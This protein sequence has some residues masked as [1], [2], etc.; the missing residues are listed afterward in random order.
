[1]GC[2]DRGKHIQYSGI[3]KFKFFSFDHKSDRIFKHERSS[4]R[5]H[6][7]HALLLAGE[8]HECRQHKHLVCSPSTFTTIV[9]TPAPPTNLA[10][11][12]VTHDRRDVV[13]DGVERGDVV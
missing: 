3:A 7:W 1:M 9:A 2:F 13:L 10:V 5:T 6:G 12:S 4:D 11:G 8:R